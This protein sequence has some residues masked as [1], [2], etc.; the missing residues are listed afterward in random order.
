MNNGL[1]FVFLLILIPIFLSTIFIPY[2]TRK[3]ESFGVTI[4]QDVYSSNI[5]KQLRKRYAIYTSISAVI[6]TAILFIINATVNNETAASINLTVAIFLYLALNFIIYLKFHF[7]M[8]KIKESS[9][10]EQGKSQ[11]LFIDTQ[12]H[13]GKLTYSNLWFL[14]SFIITILVTIFTL[15]NYH[16][17]PEQIPMQYNFSG[18]V[19]NSTEKSYRSAL[20]FPIMQFFFTFLFLFINVMI[21]RSKQQ[22]DSENP[23]ESRKRNTIFRRK[24]SLFIIITGNAFALFFSFIQLS[25]FYKFTSAT[26][27]IVTLGFTLLIIFGAIYLAY[28]T[29]QGGS[30][31][32]QTTT[33]SNGKAINR[34][35][36]RYWKLGVFYFNR[37]DPSLFLEK[38]F[39]VGWTI[40]FAR[41]LAWTFF[42]IIVAIAI[43]IP[44][45]F[46]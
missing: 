11:Q 39:G 19:S 6:L 31:I 30:R 24:W 4:P 46:S 34:D 36:D 9:N 42:L 44:L 45:L 38:R 32:Q 43:V 26:M 8:K 23:E 13:K 20:L 18:E 7:N 40:N 25:F 15:K 22:I 3:T 10:W 29:G 2:W 16:L 28:S 41:P 14:F 37:N 27:M 1:L 35:D 33:T 21:A 17:L 5:L 12:F